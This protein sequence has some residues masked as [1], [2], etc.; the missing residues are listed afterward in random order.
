MK[1]PTFRKGDKV[2]IVAGTNTGCY[3]EVIDTGD[4]WVQGQG[5]VVHVKPEGKHRGTYVGVSLKKIE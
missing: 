1:I 5:Q 2:L 4:T 3:G